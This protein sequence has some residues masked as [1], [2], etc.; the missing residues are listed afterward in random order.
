MK[1]LCLRPT[2]PCQ[3]WTLAAP[4]NTGLHPP[5]P[6]IQTGPP[7]SAIKSSSPGEEHSTFLTPSSLSTPSCAFLSFCV[8]FRICAVTPAQ[9][10]SIR[11]SLSSSNF[12]VVCAPALSLVGRSSCGTDHPQQT[13]TG[14]SP[15]PMGLG[16]GDPKALTLGP[17]ATRVNRKPETL[18]SRKALLTR[19]AFRKPVAFSVTST[20]WWKRTGS[21]SLIPSLTVRSS[22]LRWLRILP[23]LVG[24]LAV[25]S[26]LPRHPPAN[27]GGGGGAAEKTIGD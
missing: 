19:G 10:H 21:S 12:L 7:E 14:S 8:S 1:R 11:A 9:H 23:A 17:C 4:H 13:Y 5:P 16:C 25:R 3:V 27:K 15:F 22:E 6:P 2:H 26:S 24:R 20:T 18:T